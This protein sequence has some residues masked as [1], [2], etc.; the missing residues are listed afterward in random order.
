MRTKEAF[1]V[2]M[3]TCFLL[4]SRTE[5]A[6]GD[7]TGDAAVE[8]R[9]AVEVEDVGKQRQGSRRPGRKELFV[10]L[11]FSKEVTATG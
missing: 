5:R 8:I 1:R 3:M 9:H 10:H 7:G 11:V 4:P 6:I 2:R